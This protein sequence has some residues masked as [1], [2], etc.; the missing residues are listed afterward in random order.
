MRACLNCLRGGTCVRVQV[1]TCR[2]CVRIQVPTCVRTYVRKDA[3]RQRSTRAEQHDWHDWH[4]CRTYIRTC[5]FR[6]L[7]HLPSTARIT[8][9]TGTIGTTR[10]DSTTL[11]MVA[12]GTFGTSVTPC[13]VGTLGV[14]CQHGTAVTHTCAHVRTYVRAFLAAR[15]TGTDGSEGR[16]EEDAENARTFVRTR[17]D[18]CP[19]AYACSAL[20][21]PSSGA[22]AAPHRMSA[23]AYRV[24]L[25]NGEWRFM[26]VAVEA[27]EVDHNQA[28]QGFQAQ[29]STS[30]TIE[31]FKATQDLQAQ[32][33]TT[34]CSKHI[35]HNQALQGLEGVSDEGCPDAAAVAGQPVPSQQY[36]PRQAHLEEQAKHDQAFPEE[37]RFGNLLATRHGVSEKG[38]KGGGKGDQ[39]GA[40][41]R[42]PWLLDEQ[43]LDRYQL[44]YDDPG[45][46]RHHD[47]ST[48]HGSQ[49]YFSDQ[50]PQHLNHAGPG[51]EVDVQR[52][53]YMSIGEMNRNAWRDAVPF[54]TRQRFKHTQ[55]LLDDVGVHEPVRGDDLVPPDADPAYVR[56]YVP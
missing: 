41:M 16:E 25:A 7:A 43:R 23:S 18:P 14:A 31:H 32:S 3:H 33:S 40:S 52:R 39:P 44:G 15:T 22:L 26:W 46:Q 11:A 29:S 45:A 24:P 1:P 42:E 4:D 48:W 50:A 36:S 55:S 20:L 12:L 21:G 9:T 51:Y 37:Q 47:L 34:K 5:T 19:R 54:H 49:R 6:R 28:L 8:C 38:S 2:A 35:K 53:K 17:Q 13:I 30:S 56:T 27:D 10:A